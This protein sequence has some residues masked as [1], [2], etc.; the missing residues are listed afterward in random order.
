MK[1]PNIYNYHEYRAFLKDYFQ[2][3]KK[4]KVA[5]K[6]IASKLKLSAAFLSMIIK[7]KRNLDTKYLDDLSKEFKLSIQESS[8]L[9]N[10]V[11]LN[12]SEVASKRSTA[13]KKLA[14][15]SEFKTKNNEELVTHKYL[16]KW[17]YVAI[18]E[19]SFLKDFIEDPV[20][21]QEKLR[22]NI[23]R[24]EIKKALKFLK[25]NELLYENMNHLNCNDGIYKLSLANYHKQMLKI[26]AESIEDVPREKRQ[27]L[28][29]TK[30]LSPSGQE[31]AKEIINKAL[32]DLEN[33]KNDD[34]ISKEKRELYHFH[35]INVPLTGD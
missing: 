12:D 8:F 24:E 9:K 30:S 18:R 35:L 1:R 33:I 10:L 7:G 6:V 16:D 34:P 13:Y 11:V 29:F 20:W 22:I 31:K 4:H 32:L 28:A 21:I 14:R 2:F 23:K 25:K 3:L 5:A 15:F 17:Y 27:I 26:S 19:L